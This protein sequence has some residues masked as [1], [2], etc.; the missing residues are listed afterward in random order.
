MQTIIP[1]VVKANIKLFEKLSHKNII[2]TFISGNEFINLEKDKFHINKKYSTSEKYG[3]HKLICVNF[4][5]SNI[6]LNYHL[7]NED[8]ILIQD[9]PKDYM[10][11]FLF[12]SLLKK[13]DLIKKIN[14]N[15]LSNDD[16]LIIKLK[17]NDPLLSFF[18]MK[19]ETP[20]CELVKADNSKKNPYFFVTEPNNLEN[21]EINKGNYEFKFNY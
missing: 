5:I 9:K 2:K 11:L 4:N 18:T 21:K 16:F 13:D 7:D 20:H 3:G 15:K 14:K 19:K 12:I 17:F 10:D 1:K 6:N 8:F